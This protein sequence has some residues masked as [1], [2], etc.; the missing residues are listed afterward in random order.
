MAA[1]QA[2]KLSVKEKQNLL[3]GRVSEKEKTPARRGGGGNAFQNFIEVLRS[4][5]DEDL[6]NPVLGGH[7]STALPHLANI[8]F[9]VGRKLKFNG[10]T[11]KFVNDPEADKL[12]TKVYRK[13]FIVPD[14]V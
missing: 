3:Q 8:S 6:I 2:G 9:L 10:A 4:G 11:E 7:Y 5:K 13:P 14:K 12:L 1:N